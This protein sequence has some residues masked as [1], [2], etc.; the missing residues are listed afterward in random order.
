MHEQMRIFK[1]SGRA[2]IRSK[3]AAL[4]MYYT[5]VFRPAFLF[6]WLNE[7]MS[8]L[9][10]GHQRKKLTLWWGIAYLPSSLLYKAPM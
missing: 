10:V 5:I 7:E 4:Y 6:Q 8:I 1:C 2:F 3:H 9:A